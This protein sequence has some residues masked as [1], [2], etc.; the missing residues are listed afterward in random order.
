MAFIKV[1]HIIYFMI[2]LIRALKRNRIARERPRGFQQIRPLLLDVQDRHLFSLLLYLLF[3]LYQF[4]THP[5]SRVL[6]VLFFFQLTVLMISVLIAFSFI[7]YFQPLKFSL[8]QWV[9]QWG[10]V[11]SYVMLISMFALT[12]AGRL[13]DAQRKTTA[14]MVVGW[15]MFIITLHFIYMIFVI[16]LTIRD[17]IKE[18]QQEEKAKNAR[19]AGGIELTASACTNPS[20]ITNEYYNPYVSDTDSTN[21]Y[22]AV[23]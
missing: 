11:I 16:I 13:T 8:D 3:A 14:W 15:M 17:K 9:D 22:D 5:R 7:V 2:H 18:Y 1:A 21:Y 19:N 20:P 12:R 6:G 10:F 4:S 23:G